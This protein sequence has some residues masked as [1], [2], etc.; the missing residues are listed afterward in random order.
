MP[1]MRNQRLRLVQ[2]GIEEHEIGF[3]IGDVVGWR[4]SG[5]DGGSH[6]QF[7]ECGFCCVVYVAGACDMI[8]SA[9]PYSGHL[10]PASTSSPCTIPI[11]PPMTQLAI[12][13]RSDR[14][15]V[16]KAGL[17]LPFQVMPQTVGHRYKPSAQSRKHL[18][19]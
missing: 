10:R 2:Q 16:I 7:L 18:D 3:G 19:A 12:V 6:G 15:N 13:F 1:E 14:C 9:R 4:M 5:I 8:R 11:D 17:R